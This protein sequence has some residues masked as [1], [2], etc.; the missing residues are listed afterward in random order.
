MLVLFRTEIF[1]FNTKEKGD[2]EGSQM[3]TADD[4]GMV[5]RVPSHAGSST[6]TYFAGVLSAAPSA[7][8]ASSTTS[9]LFSAALFASD[10][11][12]DPVWWFHA[13]A[14][15]YPLSAATYIST[16]SRSLPNSYGTTGGNG[17]MDGYA[18][19]SLSA[20]SH[21]QSFDHSTVY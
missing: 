8:A 9:G 2:E 6:E 1:G 18:A 12:T 17:S 3:R 21:K 11:A 4:P 15:S 10:F 13:D 16:N 19:A 20:P 14:T 7:A 5:Y